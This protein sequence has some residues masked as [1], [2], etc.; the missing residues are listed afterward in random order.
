[1]EKSADLIRAVAI[2]GA[3][4]LCAAAVWALVAVLGDSDPSNAIS[5]VSTAGLILILF[6]P[7]GL[8]GMV[9]AARRPGLAWFGY[10]TTIIAFVTFVILTRQLWHNSD[11]LYGGDDWKLPG[12]AIFVAV[13]CGQVS[14]LLAWARSGTL[15]QTLAAWA[16]TA[17]VVLAALGV[18]EILAEI[19]ISD[20]IYGVLSVL[21]VLPVALLP[22][23]TLGRRADSGTP[24]PPTRGAS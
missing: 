2:A 19:E 1:M 14:L 23:V 17:I 10:A 12:V 24:R 9:L 11:I 5:K 13:A 18:L 15:A 4:A 6:S 3:V 7:I 20:R 8:A 21:Y 22:L 16:S